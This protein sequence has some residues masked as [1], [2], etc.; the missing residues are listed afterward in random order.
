MWWVFKV[1]HGVVNWCATRRTA[2]FVVS[3]LPT[4]S[5][6][7]SCEDPRRPWR[8][9][10]TSVLHG[11]STMCPLP[12]CDA[13][14]PREVC[15]HTHW[16]KSPTSNYQISYLR[17]L[18]EN[19]TKEGKS[20]LIFLL[21]P[22]HSL[23]STAVFVSSFILII[24]LHTPSSFSHTFFFPHFLLHHPNFPS[25]IFFQFCTFFFTSC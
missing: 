12:G 21:L 18:G 7:F 16:A 2:V 23:A 4:G 5:L 11:A 14:S 9:L 24:F 19:R 8:F 3:G 15:L 17:G 1:L 25:L 22:H 13:T 20:F 6:A 10:T